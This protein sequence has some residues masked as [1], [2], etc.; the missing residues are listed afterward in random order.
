MGHDAGQR[1]ELRWGLIGAPVPPAVKDENAACGD[2]PE[3]LDAG[4]TGTG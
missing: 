4:E 3:T 2:R 1:A